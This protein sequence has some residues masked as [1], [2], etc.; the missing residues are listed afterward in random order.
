MFRI[1]TGV[2]VFPREKTI[3]ADMLIYD[4]AT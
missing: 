2:Y 4:W 3:A 1:I